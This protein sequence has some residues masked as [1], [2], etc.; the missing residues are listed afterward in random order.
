MASDK[1]FFKFYNKQIFD[2]V[3]LSEYKQQ[4]AD[5]AKAVANAPRNSSDKTLAEHDHACDLLVA[6][7]IGEYLNCPHNNV[8]L[9]AFR[10][11]FKALGP[12]PELAKP[13][14]QLCQPKYRALIALGCEAYKSNALHGGEIERFDKFLIRHRLPHSLS[15]TLK[16][17]AKQCYQDIT[18]QTCKNPDPEQEAKL[19]GEFISNISR[20]ASNYM[21]ETGS[22][23]KI[24]VIV[25]LK[26]LDKV[27]TE[28][29]KDR[30][31]LSTIFESDEQYKAKLQ[32]LHTS[33][34]QKEKAFTTLLEKEMDSQSQK[35]VDGALFTYKHNSVM[36]DTK[37][38]AG[39]KQSFI[40]VDE[41]PHDYYKDAATV[42]LLTEADDN[43][44]KGLWPVDPLVERSTYPLINDTVIH[45]PEV[46][47]ELDKL[48]YYNSSKTASIE[49]ALDLEGDKIQIFH[50][51]DKGKD[52][53]EA[54][55]DLL[56][57]YVLIGGTTQCAMP[58]F[59]PLPHPTNEEESIKS[60]EY[61]CNYLKHISSATK[62][63]I[64]DGFYA[65]TKIYME[66]WGLKKGEVPNNE[67]IQAA[68]QWLG[69]FKR[70]IG[71]AKSPSI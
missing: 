9:E 34:R 12:I 22:Y 29:Y 70:Q 11:S 36:G 45:T 39:K 8:D 69:E 20:L 42:K 56:R 17:K 14:K 37:P 58:D 64:E 46:A 15:A 71:W 60:K 63:E 68:N 59:P 57:K 16:Q 33:L 27:Q 66:K 2:D 35:W 10:G 49:T 19:I 13:I 1:E 61:K 6:D 26:E 55:R 4:L 28:Y 21:S 23:S 43:T 53:T 54:K 18:E 48:S 65:L 41:L 52:A 25:A 62:E 5:T 3:F 67:Q 50:T 30:S 38:Q 24:D 7:Y 40:Y 31:L 44:I 51:L 47:P 32:T